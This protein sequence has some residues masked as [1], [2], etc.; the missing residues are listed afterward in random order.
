MWG[1]AGGEHDK[2]AV[3]LPLYTADNVYAIIV[4]LS[5]NHV[6]LTGFELPSTHRIS[7]TVQLAAV[8]A[9]Q[10]SISTLGT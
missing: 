8:T 2:P 7:N 1:F 5:K 10:L 9:T 4:A 3:L 6:A